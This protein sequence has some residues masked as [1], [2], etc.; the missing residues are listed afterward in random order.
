VFFVFQAEDGIRDRNVTGVQTCAL[1]IFLNLATAG[2]L[3]LATASDIVTDIMSMFGIEAENAS[4]ASDVFAAAHAK[5]NT[6][7]EQLSEAQ[8]GRA[9]RRE[10]EQSSVKSVSVQTQ[11]T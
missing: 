10:R 7:V 9:S 4:Q 6:N 5:S 11:V 2:Q 8:I 1:P 3:D